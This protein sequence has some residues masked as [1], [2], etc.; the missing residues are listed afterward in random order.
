MNYVR[1]TEGLKLFGARLRQFR[2]AKGLSQENLAYEANISYSQVNRIERGE[3][4]TGL[5]TVFVL[6]RTL[7]V[8]LKEL[9]DFPLPAVET[10]LS[11][12]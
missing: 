9:F 12:S 4:N 2:L 7:Q 5:S 8:D 10:P 1:D 3:I 6:A 11:A